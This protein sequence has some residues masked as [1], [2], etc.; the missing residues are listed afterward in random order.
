MKEVLG[1]AGWRIGRSS[2]GIG[3]LDGGAGFDLP[4]V[5]LD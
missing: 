3:W 4:G 1:R 5:A 2:F